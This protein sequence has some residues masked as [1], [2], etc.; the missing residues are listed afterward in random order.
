[1]NTG[2]VAHRHVKQAVVGTNGED[3]LFQFSRESSAAPD[4][5]GEFRGLHLVVVPLIFQFSNLGRDDGDA[6][7][8]NG[9]MQRGQI[10]LTQEDILA[11]ENHVRLIDVFVLLIRLELG[12]GD[13]ANLRWAE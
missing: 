2:N 4:F 7:A 8:E 12:E 1:M 13:G 9:E 5:R 6:L 10:H 3:A 11:R